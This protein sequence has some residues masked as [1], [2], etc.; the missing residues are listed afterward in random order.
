MRGGNISP[1]NYLFKDDDIFIEK[2][3][4]SEGIL[5]KENDL[6]TPAVTSIE[7]IGK[8]ARITQNYD[9]VTAGGFVFI[10]RLYSQ[11]DITSKI[12]VMRCNPHL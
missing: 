11:S 6:I 3:L 2:G 1:H 5:L 12:C 4:I 8:M 7:N 9:D 10:L